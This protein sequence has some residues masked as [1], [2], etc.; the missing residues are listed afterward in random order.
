M[1]NYVFIPCRC[2]KVIPMCLPANQTVQCS[3]MGQ[4][5]EMWLSEL[6][7]RPLLVLAGLDAAVSTQ[8]LIRDCGVP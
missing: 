6:L 1:L 8:S 2:F 3:Q 7:L 5:I 4:T